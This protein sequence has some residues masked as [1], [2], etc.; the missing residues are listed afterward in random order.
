[1][2]VTQEDYRRQVFPMTQTRNITPSAWWQWWLH[3]QAVDY[4]LLFL[5]ILPNLI[6]IL[7]DRGKWISDTSFY[8]LNATSLHHTM[9]H[10]TANWWSEM[11]AITPKPPIL[12]WVGQFFVVVGGF[13]GNINSGL[14]LTIFAAQYVGLWFLY[15]ALLNAHNRRSLALLGCLAVASAPMFILISTQFYVQPVQLL[16]VCWFLYIMVS[17]KT[18]DSL[19][20]FLHLTA[21]SAVAML[22]IM[23]SPAFCVIPGAIALHRAWG[24]RNVKISFGKAH[25]GIALAAILLTTVAAAWYL[26]NYDEA[27]AYGQYGFSYIYGAEVRDVFLLKLAEWS[28]YVRDGF[29]LIAFVS[30]LVPWG[31]VI[32]LRKEKHPWGGDAT[33]MLLLAVQVAVVLLVV[34]SSAHQTLRYVLP[35]LPYFA[36]AGIWSLFVINNKW[37]TGTLFVALGFQLV[38]A[39]AGLYL[40]DGQ[41]LK[42]DRQR[43]V[44]ALDAIT[45]AT[46]DDPRGTVWLGIGELGVFNM[47][48]IYHASKSPTYFEGNAPGFNSIELSLTTT[49]IDGD[50]EALWKEIEESRDVYIVLL[51]DPPP[52][53]GEEEA[54]DIWMTVVQGTREISNRVRRSGRFERV[55]TPDSW[56]VEIYRDGAGT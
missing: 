14:L 38:I 45:Q 15:K 42:R 8:A 4:G 48:L 27:V 22:A 54:H 24:N 7:L 18:W 34:A 12:P 29:F 56:E 33:V 26:K 32:Y 43:Y 30:L 51:K 20:T 13:I 35:I 11:L 23:S 46:A 25:L 16:A 28:R 36:V 49:E 3:N 17:S 2:V 53:S 21:A 50:V 41:V 31:V 19:F 44:A 37:L 52:P 39:N 1:M 10:D 40:W 6:W 47:D 9:L 5:M 55:V